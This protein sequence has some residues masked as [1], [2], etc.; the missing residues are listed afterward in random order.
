MIPYALLDNPLVGPHRGTEINNLSGIAWHKFVIRLL[1][2]ITRHFTPNR[3]RA[4]REDC[5]LMIFD[6]PN[7]LI[8]EV[9]EYNVPT[10]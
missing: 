3:Y 9:D 10:I 1:S 4:G 7:P 5:L 8:G 2:G 6:V